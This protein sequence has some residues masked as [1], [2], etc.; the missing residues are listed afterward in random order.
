MLHL[1]V[2]SI[3]ILNFWWFLHRFFKHCSNDKLVK[4]KLKIVTVRVKCLSKK[5]KVKHIN[6]VKKK[7]FEKFSAPRPYNGV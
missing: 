6:F 2:V 7:N 5:N 4:M 1:P 3:E